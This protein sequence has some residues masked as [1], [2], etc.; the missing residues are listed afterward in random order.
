MNSNLCFCYY[1]VLSDRDPWKYVFGINFQ[2]VGHVPVLVCQ[3]YYRQFSDWM[4]TWETRR[5]PKF[6][7][8]SFLTSIGI[9]A[10]LDHHS[11]RVT[12]ATHSFILCF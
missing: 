8:V 9:S 1:V 4:R 11:Y 3:H 10:R 7:E 12:K 5:F 2:L 6:A